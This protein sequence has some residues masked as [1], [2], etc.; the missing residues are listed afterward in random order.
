VNFYYFNTHVE[1]VEELHANHF[2]GGLFIYDVTKGESFTK[3]AR[4]IDSDKEF[5]YLVAA[6]P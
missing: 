1:D 4:V 3:I 2:Y 6:R 5:K